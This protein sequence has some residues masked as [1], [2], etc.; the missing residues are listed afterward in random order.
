MRRAATSKALQC[1]RI[2]RWQIRAAMFETLH[3]LA[4]L[5]SMLHSTAY[6]ALQRRRKSCG[7][8]KISN[9]YRHTPLWDPSKQVRLLYLY[10]GTNNSDIRLGLQVWDHELA[11]SYIAISY[12]WG[13][14]HDDHHET[15][16]VNGLPRKVRPNCL[17]ALWQV[18]LHQPG[19]FVWIDSLCI[20]QS[21]LEE[22]TH[23]VE[24]MGEIYSRAHLTYACVGPAEE[25]NYLLSDMISTLEVLDLTFPANIYLDFDEDYDHVNHL[26]ETWRTTYSR[27]QVRD[28]L[29]SA[30][31][32]FA[33]PYWSQLWII[34]E[35]V[36]SKSVQILFG[37]EIKSWQAIR[38][39]IWLC[40]CD[41]NVTYSPQFLTLADLSHAS[42]LSPNQLLDG[43][44]FDF[45]CRDG[46]D[47]IFA[48]LSILDWPEGVPPIKLDFTQSMLELAISLAPGA[49]TPDIE[50]LGRMLNSFK[51]TMHDPIMSKLI[52]RRQT[53][54]TPLPSLSRTPRMTIECRTT[55]YREVY[56]NRSGH[57][58]LALLHERTDTEWNN[59]DR[60][61]TLQRLSEVEA[62]DPRFAGRPSRILYVGDRP[63][64]VV[65]SETEL[66]D[67]TAQC[68]RQS[69]DLLM[70]LRQSSTDLLEVIGQ[71][72]L[73]P[74]T[75]F[76]WRNLR[77]INNSSMNPGSR[78]SNNT[79]KCNNCKI[80]KPS[81]R[82]SD[83]RIDMSGPHPPYRRTAIHL[84]IDLSAEDILIWI[85]QDLE[86]DSRN[87]ISNAR[88]ERLI[89]RMSEGANPIAR[90][91]EP[92]KGEL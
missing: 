45:Q 52:S 76:C 80:D 24:M 83:R 57:W 37:E 71:G 78:D 3:I 32:F 65:C 91:I 59:E 63:A 64:A 88:L 38:K 43:T 44:T 69:P 74:G 68:S 72:F 77:S 70:V 54:P 33:R 6:K 1:A 81:P 9:S 87:Y 5:G 84:R 13:D 89:T 75:E 20:D 35:I 86:Q 48:V 10:P 22:K 79:E 90:I 73:L 66:G 25:H 27:N 60:H 62:K 12:A 39:L 85:S 49:V 11:P 26:W 23:Q 36:V 42:K 47:R 40:W 8:D 28:L 16:Y 41:S 15:L 82:S 53:A 2:L 17:Y 67:Y 7:K 46:R 29:M 14:S 50:D 4:R 51:V 61:H 31:N 30:R 34:Q 56:A 55:E 58:Q 92:L 18:R 21:H 19:S